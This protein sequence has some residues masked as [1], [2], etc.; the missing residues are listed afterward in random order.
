[1][2][3][4]SECHKDFMTW[5]KFSRHMVGHHGVNRDQ[6]WRRANQIGDLPCVALRS[7][8]GHWYLMVQSPLAL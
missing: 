6:F 5:S 3:H 8:H 4:C 2:K 7:E 1:M